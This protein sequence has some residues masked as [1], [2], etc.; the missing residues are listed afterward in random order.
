MRGIRI[1][2]VLGCGLSG[3]SLTGSIEVDFGEVVLEPESYFQMEPGTQGELE[4]AGVTLPHESPFF[5][6]FG[7]FT[8]SNQTDTT[9]PGFFNAGSA[10]PGMGDGD[11]TYAIGNVFGVSSLEITFTTPGGVQLESLAVSNTTY[12]ALSM[13]NGDEFAKKFGG[14]DGTDADFFKLILTPISTE[15][16]SL[17]ERE[18]Y[19][20]DFR[21]ADPEEDFILERWQTVELGEYPGGIGGIR[22]SLESTDSGQ[23]GMNTPAY[24]ALDTLRFTPAVDYGVLNNYLASYTGG[25]VDTGNWLGWVFIENYPWVWLESLEKYVYV[26]ES[27]WLYLPR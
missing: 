27:N 3:G 8:V 19:F 24:F 26:T 7:L 5:G 21:S 6:G 23:F 22:F 14:P 1:W 20:A 18:I 25:F 4:F 13:R 12:A 16:H 9:T 15:G 11:A 10:F 2:I 17:G